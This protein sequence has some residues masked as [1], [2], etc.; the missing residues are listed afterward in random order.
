MKTK[1]KFDWDYLFDADE[2]TKEGN[3]E[4]RDHVVTREDLTI[5]D[6][7]LR[8]KEEK[9]KAEMPDNVADLMRTKAV[10]F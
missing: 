6:M 4:I 9:V 1:S 8:D 3:R 5:E 7:L 2:T 10:P